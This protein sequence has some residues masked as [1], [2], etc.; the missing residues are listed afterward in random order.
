[1]YYLR[2]EN[3]GADQVC[4]YR[5]DQLCSYRPADLCLC[6]HIYAESR[7]SHDDADLL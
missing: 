6:F 1:M 3:K 7:F 5:A 4:C 2:K